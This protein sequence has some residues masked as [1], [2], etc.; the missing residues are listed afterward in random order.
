MLCQ[1]N[2]VVL[3]IEFYWQWPAF[4][5]GCEVNL[6]FIL[7]D[8]KLRLK[9]AAFILEIKNFQFQYQLPNGG[10]SVSNEGTVEVFGV[11]RPL[12]MLPSDNLT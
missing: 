4:F 2:L 1:Q 6:K 3:L 10:S 12:Q 5:I 8:S 9:A 7:L 11:D